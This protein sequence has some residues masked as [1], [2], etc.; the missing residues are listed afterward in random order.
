VATPTWTTINEGLSTIT[1]NLNDLNLL[2]GDPLDEWELQDATS[3]NNSGLIVG[4][5]NFNSNPHGFLL[6]PGAGAGSA[7]LVI[8]MTSEPKTIKKNVPLNYSITITNLGPDPATNVR[9]IDWLPPKTLFRN[10]ATNRGG[11]TKQEDN[12]AR[13]IFSTIA[14]NETVNAS[15]F[16]E[17]LEADISLR[18]IVRVKGNEGDPDFSNNTTGT[19]QSISVDR[20]FIATAAYGSF[21]D[22]H[23]TEL[24]NFRDNYLLTN[25]I[26]RYF[27][28]L[29]YRY[30][31]PVAKTISKDENLRLLTRIGLAPIVYA[32]TYP[33]WFMA[34]LILLVAFLI[35]RQQINK[36]QALLAH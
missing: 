32:V 30:S 27:V 26:G 1:T 14:V 34:G 13:C 25:R 35:Y 19:S 22:P 9:L 17:P 5:G 16:I 4:Y 11:C 8:S 12:I 33:L 28:A 10:A 6:T 7:D 3:I 21:L 23:V 36:R 15:F 29:Y 2:I 24:R 20:C 18:N 31:P